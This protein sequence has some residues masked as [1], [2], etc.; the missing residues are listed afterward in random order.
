MSCK[1]CP[2]QN[3][4]GEKFLCRNR[5]GVRLHSGKHIENG[6]IGNENQHRITQCNGLHR[7]QVRQVLLQ[8]VYL[9]DRYDGERNRY[10]DS[11]VHFR[12]ISSV[13]SVVVSQMLVY[14]R[15]EN[16]DSGSIPNIGFYLKWKHSVIPYKQ[17]FS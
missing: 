9:Y 4:L 3:A 15:Q 1:T 11:D 13:V 7:C 16:A 2:I 5:Q 17:E 14:K 10:H 12:S 6:K 8:H